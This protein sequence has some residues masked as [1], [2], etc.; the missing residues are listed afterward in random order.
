M[1]QQ[2]LRRR[3]WLVA[4]ILGVAFVCCSLAGDEPAST[5]PPESTVRLMI[6]YGDGSQ[7][8]FTSLAW[9]EKMTVFDALK[10]AEKHPRGIKVTHTGSGA[11]VFITAIDDL[12]NEGA[13]GRNWRYTVNDQPAGVGAG[14]MELKAGDAIVW[15]FEK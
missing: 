14:G 6:D 11:G 3:N 1:C 8:T 9:K 10:A 12:K 15:R 2:R 7:K 13:D 4:C 5:V